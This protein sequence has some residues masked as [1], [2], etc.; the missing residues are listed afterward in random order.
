MRG[1]K[2]GRK[3]WDRERFSEGD[4]IWSEQEEERLRKID[5]GRMKKMRKKRN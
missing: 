2:R 4:E 1:R 3:E 5:L